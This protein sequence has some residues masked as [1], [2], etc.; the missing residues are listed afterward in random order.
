MSSGVC[1]DH[2]RALGEHAWCALRMG[3]D[4]TQVGLVQRLEQSLQCCCLLFQL[5]RE[6]VQVLVAARS[7]VVELM[8][9]LEV[10]G[11]SVHDNLNLLAPPAFNRREVCDKVL[12]RP[13][14]ITGHRRSWI[15]HCVTAVIMSPLQPF[16]SSA[17]YGG[18]II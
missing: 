5:L 9:R 8:D 18:R 4:L 12:L 10:P 13:S 17:I 2:H 14:L 16:M 1:V 11:P 6:L 15:V 3:H 7:P